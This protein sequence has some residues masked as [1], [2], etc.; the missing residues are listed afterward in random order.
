MH[1]AQA[2]TVGSAGF[3]RLS[4]YFPKAILT[5]ARYV[6]VDKVPV[7]PLAKLGLSAPEFLQFEQMEA[8]GIT[9]R[10]TFFVQK[11]AVRSE[12]LF[13]HEM[14]HVVQWHEL[15]P[16]G[17]LKKYAA[18]LFANGYRGSPLEVMAYAAEEHFTNTNEVFDAARYVKDELR[19]L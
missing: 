7:P 3:P 9:Y 5:E 15:G 11:Q 10:S 4:E 13:F 1:R 6:A 2:A 12:A 17:F 8:L 18:G 16:E 14:I 19:R